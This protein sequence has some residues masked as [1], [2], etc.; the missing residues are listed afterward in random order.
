M[1]EKGTSAP[2]KGLE[3]SEVSAAVFE[4]L[5]EYTAFPWPVLMAQAQRRGVVPESLTIA[6]LEVLLPLLARG[7]ERFTSPEAGEK[8]RERLSALI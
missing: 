1:I 7:V 6:D 2:P 4:I 3:L 8:V 5:S